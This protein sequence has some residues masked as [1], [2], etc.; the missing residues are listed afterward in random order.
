MAKQNYLQ[1]Q[2]VGGLMHGQGGAGII[3]GFCGSIK[4]HPQDNN[5]C[6]SH[7]SIYVVIQTIDMGW[8]TYFTQVMS[9]RLSHST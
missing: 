9:I 2:S 8:A 3:A 4:G 1:E 6:Y 7:S 5:G